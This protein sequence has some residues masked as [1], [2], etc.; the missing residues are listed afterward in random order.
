MSEPG[1]RSGHEPIVRFDGV[2]K[3]FRRHRV[4]PFL[5]RNVLL[6][7]LGRATEP[8]RLW[9][10]DDVSFELQRGEA[11]GIVGLNGTGKST[12]LKLIAGG[13]IATSGRIAVRGRIAP[14]L[15]L[16]LG[17]H[18]DMTGR[19]CLELNARLLGYTKAEL[20]ARHDEIVAFAEL[21]NALD[22]PTRFYS[23]GMQARLGF[24]I[25]LHVDPDLMLLDEVLAVGDH[26][27]RAKCFDRIEQLR[28][29][30]TT[31]VIVSHVTEALERA[32]TRVMW[33]RRGKIA[34]DGSPAEVCAAYLAE[35]G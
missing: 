10:I 35:R 26:A 9:P 2:S 11:V 14:I 28:A 4:R 21:E 29:R 7:A 32:C 34:L 15:S 17:F 6:R 33:L 22:T 13:C 27:F 24:S 12:L 20:R 31:F 25:A 3:M 5:L 8:D 18:P 30:G 23:S 19:E 1:D 16:G